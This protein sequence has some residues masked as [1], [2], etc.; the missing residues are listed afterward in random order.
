MT[1]KIQSSSKFLLFKNYKLF[2][3][4]FIVQIQYSPVYKA[5]KYE[6]SITRP[7]YLEHATS[8]SNIQAVFETSKSR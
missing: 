7:I 2:G 8:C 4:H 6:I 1:C 3:E 5:V